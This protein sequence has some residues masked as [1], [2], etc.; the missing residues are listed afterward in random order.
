MLPFLRR[1]LVKILYREYSNKMLT[2]TFN[3]EGNSG[4]EI[5]LFLCPRCTIV[6]TYKRRFQILYRKN[7]KF[8]EVSSTKYRGFSFLWWLEWELNKTNCL[9][10]ELPLE[11]FLSRKVGK[12]KLF[13]RPSSNQFSCNLMPTLMWFLKVIHW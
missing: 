4:H 5:L 7:K 10:T 9:L 11:Y 2:T 3:V 6:W 1:K 13:S 12:K 8:C